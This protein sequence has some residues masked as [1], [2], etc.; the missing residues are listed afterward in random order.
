[1]FMPETVRHLH[2]VPPVPDDAVADAAAEPKPIGA[3]SKPFLREVDPDV[4]SANR[5]RIRKIYVVAAGLITLVLGSAF[6][7]VDKTV[8]H[9]ISDVA[10]RVWSL[11][12]KDS[13]PP[14][15]VQRF[16]AVNKV[17]TGYSAVCD[18][19]V[20]DYP[21]LEFRKSGKK[22]PVLEDGDPF[23]DLYFGIIT[24]VVDDVKASCPVEFP[25]GGEDGPVFRS[26]M[27]CEVER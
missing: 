12:Y 1:M 25:S 26:K 23:A 27:D 24:S 13:V 15:Y 16:C 5:E 6:F 3:R 7:G 8:N 2:S 14:E 4:E 17:G 21:V 22:F 18:G 10:E 11:R 9:F 20:D 19:A